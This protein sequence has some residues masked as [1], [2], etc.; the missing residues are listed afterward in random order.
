MKMMVLAAVILMVLP[1]CL[2]FRSFAL[3]EYTVEFE[4]LQKQETVNMRKADGTVVDMT[5]IEV[6]DLVS[7]ILGATGSIDAAKVITIAVAGDPGAIT[8]WQGQCYV[9]KERKS[10]MKFTWYDKAKKKEKK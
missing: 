7:L 1:G 6:I 4:P 3:F 5:P 10:L 9:V 8:A 2:G